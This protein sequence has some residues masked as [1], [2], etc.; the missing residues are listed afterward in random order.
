MDTQRVTGVQS[1]SKLMSLS[2]LQVGN[3]AIV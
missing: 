3:A 1:E 2:L